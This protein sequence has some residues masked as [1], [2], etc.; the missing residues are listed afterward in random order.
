MTSERAVFPRQEGL[1]YLA[2]GGTE[3]EIMYR[4]GHELRE[5]A[6]FELMNKPAAVA[7]M[8]DMYRRYLDMA[9]KHGFAALLAGFDYRASP[10]WGDKLGYSAEG[11]REMQHKCI[12][13]LRDVARPYA[14]QLP[15]VAVA[16]CVG[17]RGDAYALNRDITADEAKAYHATQ[18]Q[19]LKECGVDLVWAATINNVPEAVGI[20]RAAASAGLPVNVSFT[21][22]SRHRLRS[23]PTLK[24]AI[25]AT[26]AQA[27]PARPD[28]FGI[29]CSHPV[30]FEP[31][32]EPG[33]WTRRIRSLR[34]NAAKMDKVSLCKLGHIEEGD[35]EELGLMMG[36]LARRYPDIDIWG[37]CCGTWDKHFDRIAY[38]VGQA[39]CETMP[40]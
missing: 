5:F 37:G 1:L 9:A 33:E 17:P 36:D 8:T 6:M 28:S 7:D 40:T 31:A 32:L 14:G 12:D 3:T 15:R 11:L 13:F 38:H 35:P 10:D 22:D 23:G 4:H 27:G 20:S 25:E 19:T 30:E 39:R 26:D 24:E 21:L 18:M 2:E 34:P 16:G 29:N